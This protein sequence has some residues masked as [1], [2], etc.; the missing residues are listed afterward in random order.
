MRTPFSDLDLNRLVHE[1]ARLGILT[2]LSACDEADFLFLLNLTGLTKGNLSSHLSKL[3]QGGLVAIRKT[4][5]GKQPVTYVRLTPEGRAALKVH[6]KRLD[7]LRTAGQRLRLR[8][9]E[10]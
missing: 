3:E 6:W 7:V 5:E 4:F 8:T 10:P 1:P 9:L 2:A